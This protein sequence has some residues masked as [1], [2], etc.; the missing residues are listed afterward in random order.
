MPSSTIAAASPRTLRRQQKIQEI[1]DAAMALVI[2]RGIESLTV[3]AL[4]YETHCTPGALYRYFGSKDEILAA[5]D[6]QILDSFIDVFERGL[7]IGLDHLQRHPIDDPLAA[8]LF[9]T[10][11]LC[12]IYRQLSDLQPRQF[13]MLCLLVSTPRSWVKDEAAVHAIR[14]S[15]YLLNMVSEQLDAAAT[16]GA[17]SALAVDASSL[18][19]AFILWSSIH[20]LQER[21]KLGR[22]MPTSV[23]IPHLHAAL[24]SAL[25]HG[26]GAPLPALT[27]ASASLAALNDPAWVV[28]RCLA[29]P[30]H[31][32]STST[33]HP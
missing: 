30:F 18:E 19:R 4:A 31:P 5:L 10:L 2:D 28:A 16:C 17:L 26:W 32:P 1:L 24:V 6:V 14:P 11:L 12:D 22:L 33:S 8:A 29:A 20:G 23:V 7:L 3:Q 27:I 21:R 15:M 25:L 13:H 9:P